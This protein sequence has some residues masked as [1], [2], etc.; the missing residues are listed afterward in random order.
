VSK[1]IS[2]GGRWFAP[3]ESLSSRQDG[4]CIVQLEDAGLLALITAG[5]QGLDDEPTARRV[6][7]AALRSDKFH[8]ILA[9]FLVE[10]DVPWTPE[11]AEQ[12]AKFFAD[13]SD[14]ESK[15]AMLNVF[16]GLL[17]GFFTVAVPSLTPT[18][19]VSTALTASQRTARRR[20]GRS[21]A[22]PEAVGASAPGGSP[23]ATATA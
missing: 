2:L 10:S 15:Q 7:V 3:A 17:H 8:H 22:T 13:I 4:W 9:G 20:A 19:I 6:V 11:S 16:V 14:L 1:V 23:T 5:K 21:T 12:N 18:P